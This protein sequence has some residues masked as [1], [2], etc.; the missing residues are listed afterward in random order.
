MLIV[1]TYYKL[2]QQTAVNWGF[3]HSINMCTINYYIH[4]VIGNNRQPNYDNVN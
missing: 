4:L 2:Y 3:Y 1:R